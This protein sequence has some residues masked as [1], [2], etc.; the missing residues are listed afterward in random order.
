MHVLQEAE[1]TSLEKGRY[2]NNPLD[3]RRGE[4]PIRRWRLEEG[5]E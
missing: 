5:G 3:K 2:K 4:V 1:T